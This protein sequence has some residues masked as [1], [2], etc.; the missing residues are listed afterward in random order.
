[1]YKPR[2]ENEDIGEGKI[3]I[4]KVRRKFIFVYVCVQTLY[5]VLLLVIFATS[6]FSRS[7]LVMC[8]AAAV[9]MFKM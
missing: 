5:F 8:C 1:M 4:L 9:G 3:G 7:S 6:R 2:K